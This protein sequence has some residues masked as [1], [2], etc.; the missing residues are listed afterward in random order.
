MNDKTF[1]VVRKIKQK[2]EPV[3]KKK[4]VIEFRSCKVKNLESKK[5]KAD[6][7]DDQVR[8]YD[9]IIKPPASKFRAK[10]ILILVKKK[11]EQDADDVD[12]H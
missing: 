3:I 7:I 9:G 4:L 10:Y 5:D 12:L 2:P 1:L 8:L 6:Q 11:W